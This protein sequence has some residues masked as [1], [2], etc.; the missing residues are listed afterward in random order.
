MLWNLIDHS[1]LLR[2]SKIKGKKVL[3]GPKGTSLYVSAGLVWSLAPLGVT[4]LILCSYAGPQ[5][6]EKE[7]PFPRSL[8]SSFRSKQTHTTYTPC[9]GEL[10]LGSFPLFFSPFLQIGQITPSLQSTGNLSPLQ[11][12]Y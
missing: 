5:L 6:I 2:W 3:T 4:R 11:S 7:L 1:G 9:S 8:S 10:F 12:V